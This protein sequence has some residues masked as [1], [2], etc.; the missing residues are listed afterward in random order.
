[1]VFMMLVVYGARFE[2]FVHKALKLLFIIFHQT[3]VLLE[4]RASHRD[5]SFTL[6]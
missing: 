5:S 3:L 4:A 6:H 2:R 1:M